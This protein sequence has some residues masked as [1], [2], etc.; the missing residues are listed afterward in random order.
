MSPRDSVT[1]RIPASTA[2]LGPG[3][4]C[5]GLALE[6][7]NTVELSL[8][9]E[10]TVQITGEG[11]GHLP[12]GP[13]NLVLQAADRLAEQV[14]SSVPGW[15]LRQHNDIPLARGLGS[16]SAAIVGGLIAANELLQADLDRQQLLDIATEIEGHPDN[17]APALFG[18]L[19]A[20]CVDAEDV[21]C[22]RLDAPRELDIGVVIPRFEVSTRR[23]REV[24]PGEVSFGDAVFNLS[25]ATCTLAALVAG[26]W[27]L[28]SA[29]MKDRLHQPHRA[30]LVPGMEEVIEAAEEAGA[31]GAALSGS[32]PTVVAFATEQRAAILNA[33]VAAFGNFNVEATSFWTK[34]NNHGAVIVDEEVS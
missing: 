18:G 34:P 5:L 21:C 32:G 7:H 25:R 24:L 29:V 3:F 30:S 1:V 26:R 12:L 20:C 13:N 17:V 14:E 22:I 11:Q 8:A 27:E 31:H 4:D 9:V 19:T 6:I 10:T 2:N 16:S 23:A 15:H 28:L 33:M